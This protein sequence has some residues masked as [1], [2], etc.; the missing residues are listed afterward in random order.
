VKTG[1]IVVIPADTPHPFFNAGDATLRRIEIHP[2]PRFYSDESHMRRFRILLAQSFFLFV[3]ADDR[4]SFLNRYR[5]KSDV[6]Y[7]ERSRL[8]SGV[9]RMATAPV[10]VAFLVSFLRQLQVI[11]TQDVVQQLPVDAG[12]RSGRHLAASRRAS[13]DNG[14]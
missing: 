7:P 14:L 10:G 5:S 4:D 2:S 1:G 6:I 9:H 3:Q 13:L 11:P 8:T 12:L